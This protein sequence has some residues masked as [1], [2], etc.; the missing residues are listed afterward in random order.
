MGRYNVGL[1]QGSL[2]YGCRGGSEQ[3]LDYPS[4][5]GDTNERESGIR[6]INS[7]CFFLTNLKRRELL[8]CTQTRIFEAGK[9]ASVDENQKDASDSF[10][11]WH[12]LDCF[13][14]VWGGNT[15]QVSP[16]TTLDFYWRMNGMGLSR[17][18]ARSTLHHCSCRRIWR[19]PG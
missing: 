12:S 8:C 1:D 9:L 4:K 16:M 18:L 17:Y 5:Y 10:F 15:G 13:C 7:L 6:P 2:L 14:R 11:G 3:G 19:V